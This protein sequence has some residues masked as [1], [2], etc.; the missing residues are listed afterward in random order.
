MTR[1]NYLFLKAILGLVFCLS[2][3]FGLTDSVQADTCTW[4]GD[5]NADWMLAGNWSCGHVPQAADAVTIPSATP[6]NPVIY[7]NSEYQIIGVSSLT[8][9]EGAQ[10]TV[11][12]GNNGGQMPEMPS[13]DNKGEPQ[14]GDNNNN[15][16]NGGPTM[17]NGNG[18]Q[19]TA[20]QQPNGNFIGGDSG[21]SLKYT[22]DQIA[23]YSDIFD[24]AETDADNLDEQRVIA[25]LKELSEG[26]VTEALDTDSVITYFVAHNFVMNY[27]SYTGSMLHNYYLYENDGKLSMLPWDYN[28]AF[29]AFMGQ[30]KSGFGAND[31]TTIVNYGIDSPLSGTSEEDRPMWS[32][33]TSNEEYLTKYHEVM[34]NLI[35]NYFESGD[36]QTEIDKIYEMI[37]PYVEK[38]SAGFYSADE[39]KTAVTT[40]KTFC[41]KRAESI[42]LQLNGTLSTVTSEQ[43]ADA[44]V[45]ASDI[46]ISDMGSQGSTNG[47][48]PQ[49][50]DAPQQ[51]N[52]E[53]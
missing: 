43:S 53:E 11:N 42:R 41:T 37:L 34:D 51:K 13:G 19:N 12:N 44:K 14:N 5:G 16:Q 4:D 31:A 30:N 24:N 33:I 9:D 38:D 2:L 25:A 29:G 49:K 28:L 1:N 46:T 26:N 47:N 40:L 52:T 35:T 36:F 27:D 22:D 32:W 50:Q 6:N 7:A 3:A 23:S 17:P 10:L 21:A 39:F 45:D 8:I 20:P 15:P 18:G 48:M